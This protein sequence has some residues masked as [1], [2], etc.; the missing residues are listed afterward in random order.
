MVTIIMEYQIYKFEFEA[1]SFEHAMTIA[2]EKHDRMGLIGR[3]YVYSSC[4]K[5]GV[6]NN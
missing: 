3:A 4:G 6:V 5:I 1:M 2:K